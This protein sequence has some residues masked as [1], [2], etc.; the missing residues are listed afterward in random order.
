MKKLFIF[1]VFTI[2][3]LNLAGCMTTYGNFT[4]ASTSINQ[5]MAND[6]ANQLAM[7][8]PPAQ[9]RLNIKQSVSDSYGMALI[10]YLRLKG[11]AIDV[12][13][14][15]KTQSRQMPGLDFQYVLDVPAGSNFY[16]VTV[17]VGQ[18][19]LS[20]VYRPAQN[21]KVYAAG[22]WVRKE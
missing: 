17:F 2:S 20:Q 21:G 10:Q 8:Y 13:D 14:Q 19:S 5:Q 11:Y 22:S 9:T 15:N 16:R 4:S 12:V 18:Q 7:L 3:M 1:M 6:T